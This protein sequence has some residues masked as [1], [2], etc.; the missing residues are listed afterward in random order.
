MNKTLAVFNSDQES[1]DGKRF[2][3][4]AL[5][6]GI[7]MTA[8]YGVPSNL[9]HD[10]HRP[11][12]W[13]YAKGLYF[14]P[15]KVLTVGYMLLASDDNDMATISAARQKF[16]ANLQNREIAPYADDFIKELGP[17]YQEQGG[18][19]F[20]S[21]MVLYGYDNIVLKAFPR[22]AE[23]IANDK[24]GLVNLDYLLS[25]FDYLTQGAFKK[26]GSNLGII[27]HPYFRK[28]LSMYNN[29]HWIFLDELV[30]LYK[31]YDI[32]IKLHI[33]PNYLGYSPSFIPTHE[34]EYW[35]GPKFDDDISAIQ[36][37]LTQ[38]GSE[39]FERLYYNILRTEFVWKSEENLHT[40]ELE[41]VRDQP[42]PTLVDTYACRYVHS[43]FDKER[44]V[45]DHFDGAIR[46]YDTEL[47]LER[48]E[49]KM[50]E[51]GRRSQYTKLFRIDGNLPLANWKSLVTNYM[52][53]NPQ[54]YEYFG[55]PKPGIQNVA[56][57]EKYLSFEKYI[58]YS[59][60]EGDGVRLYTS[61][62]DMLKEQPEDRFICFKDEIT[63]DDGKHDA[64]EYFTIEL[65][66]ALQRVGIE[67]SLPKDCKLL[68]PEDYYA[69]IPC[70]FH[71]DKNTQ[72]LLNGTLKGV[73][74]LL[75]RLV[76]FRKKEVLSL[77]FSWHMEDKLSVVSALG[78][79]SDLEIWFNSFEE[80]PVGREKYKEWLTLQA[81]FIKKHGRPTVTPALA[82]VVYDDG[83][84]YI[85]RRSVRKDAKLIFPDQENFR[86]VAVEVPNEDVVLAQLLDEK[87]FS[88]SPLLLLKK[89]VCEKTGLDYLESPLSVVLDDNVKQ[90]LDECELLN[91]HWTDRPRPVAFV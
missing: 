21:G 67:L 73:R 12:G 20:S 36:T 6:D 17:L 69:N 43:I 50:T 14:E 4:S 45:F 9:S 23:H 1:R 62:H 51:M 35:W 49:K 89:M 8:I 11:V 22:L 65:K 44:K 31:K 18:N 86:E 58:P 39:E 3:I 64:I 84:L 71:G 72:E 10:V 33:E 66:K 79:V 76:K 85:K 55:L 16:F 28:S 30:A 19:W 82:K 26:K 52:Q 59:I 2:A 78:H 74:V 80:I 29:F 34:F 63:L 91:F 37:G 54:I 83:T 25:E 87:R 90:R 7:W 56:D 81:T 42:A 61:Y 46:A 13:A 75:N 60:N 48:V 88:V 41:E 57:E 77:T 15:D 38:Y 24:D 27:V 70:I 5:E 47:M 32:T 68:I 53:G 40:L